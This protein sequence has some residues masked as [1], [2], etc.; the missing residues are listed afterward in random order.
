MH[1]LISPPSVN[2]AA[3][4]SPLSRPGPLLHQGEQ[5]SSPGLTKK[6]KKAAKMEG[7]RL[8]RQKN[9]GI[10]EVM[11]MFEVYFKVSE[12]SIVGAYRKKKQ[13]IEKLEKKYE[14]ARA[15]KVAES[16]SAEQWPQRYF[17]SAN[18]SLI[19]KLRFRGRLVIDKQL[20]AAFR[21]VAKFI[22][23]VAFIRRSKPTGNVNVEE[24][25]V[26]LFQERYR[27]KDAVCEV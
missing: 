27:T 19:Y 22:S 4:P 1:M 11:L 17:S 23:C 9:V 14:E 21:S 7:S 10:H 26:Q 13:F 24:E 12:D 16:G 8:T 6:K 25:A 15:R 3:D 2:T 5:L 18:R 20:K